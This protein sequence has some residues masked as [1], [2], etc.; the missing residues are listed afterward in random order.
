MMSIVKYYSFA[1]VIEKE[2]KD[3]GYI[4]YSPT[5]PGCFSNG[6][7]V[8]ETRRNMRAAVAEHV[9]ILIELGRPVPQGEGIVHVEGLTLGIPA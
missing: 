9:E 7:T 5:L 8:E 2:P 4:A 3:P 6:L 1:I